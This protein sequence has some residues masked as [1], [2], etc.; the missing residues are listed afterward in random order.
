MPA[1]H[2]GCFL[3]AEVSGNLSLPL[4]TTKTLSIDSFPFLGPHC[5]HAIQ[6]RIPALPAFWFLAYPG[7][8]PPT[9]ALVLAWEVFP[10]PGTGEGC[11]LVSP[12]PPVALPH[13]TGHAVLVSSVG[14]SVSPL[15][16]ELLHYRGLV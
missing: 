4:Q 6:P 3:S 2:S 8:P 1:L 12:Q 7:P 15:D 9:A 16:Q 11:F 13:N 10:E 14:V 5:G